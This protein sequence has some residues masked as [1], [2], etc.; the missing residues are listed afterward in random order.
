MNPKL[1]HTSSPSVI[2]RRLVEILLAAILSSGQMRGA[3]V[4][5]DWSNGPGAELLDFAGI[6]L[7]SGDP[8]MSDG[9]ILELGYYTLGTTPNPFAGTWI[10]LSGPNGPPA[11]TSTIGDKGVFNLMGRFDLS[12]TY[13]DLATAPSPPASGIPFVIRFYD[14][15]SLDT[16]NYFNAVS[17][18]SGTWNSV[19][20]TDPQTILNLTLSDTGLVWQGGPDSAFRTTIPI[21]EP[22]SGVLVPVAWAFTLLRRRRS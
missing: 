21:P 14:S 18:D 11:G 12:S 1:G 8:G 9:A 3:S 6:P 19:L 2:A 15:P 7:P 5:V 17:N 16:A 22:V 13:S 20:P 10:P 4:R